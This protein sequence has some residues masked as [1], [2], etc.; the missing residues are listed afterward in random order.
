MFVSLDSEDPLYTYESLK[1]EIEKSKPKVVRHWNHEEY[2]KSIEY[3]IWIANENE[4]YIA[5]TYLKAPNIESNVN[6]P[7]TAVRISSEGRVYVGTIGGH[8]VGLI[9]TENQGN[10][11]QHEVMKHLQ[12]FPNAK[13]IISAGI[14]Y[15]FPQEKVKLGDVIVSDKII[16]H[17]IPRMNE[18]SQT[19]RGEVRV[20]SP[21]IRSVFCGSLET[22][23]AIKVSKDR[24]SKFRKGAIVSSSMLIDSE[25]F[26][27]EVY[28]VY[29][30]YCPLGGEMEGGVLLKLEQPHQRSVII[31][32][33]ICDFAAGKNKKWQITS[34]KA[35]FHVLEY[36][37]D[38]IPRN[39]K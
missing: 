6:D 36:Q 10:E 34:A 8:S 35:A 11:S 38:Q 30:H 5:T 19:A 15:G 28:D 37:L 18:R 21:N 33:G 3:V 27:D 9:K 29:K 12:L 1:E 2:R 23:E 4:Y 16:N 14:C 32:K 25:H 31:L 39:F 22:V 17:S 7:N 24:I 26:R 20:V 13:C